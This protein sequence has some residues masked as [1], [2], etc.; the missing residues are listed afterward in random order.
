MAIWARRGVSSRGQVSQGLA[1]QVE[2]TECKGEQRVKNE[3]ETVFPRE[4]AVLEL[5]KLL[6]SKSKGD[7]ITA[8]EVLEQTGMSIEKLRGRIKTWAKRKS[9]VL[10]PVPNDGY[11]ILADS[12]HVDYTI[13]RTKTA[14]KSE[15]E[16]LRSLA[17]TDAS[18][19]DDAQVRR[20]EWLMPRVASRVARA[21]QDSKDTKREFKLTERAPLRVL[22]GKV[23]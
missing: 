11:R 16:A 6:A 10:A 20:H 7:R 17:V 9:L 13:R 19:L 5:E 23:G 15:K 3:I 4:A 21:E 12:E 22:V 8:R 1:G 18:K 2:G 14:L